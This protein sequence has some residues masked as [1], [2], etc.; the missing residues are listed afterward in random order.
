MT[1]KPKPKPL[2]HKYDTVKERISKNIKRK[3]N[4]SKYN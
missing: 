3:P 2:P 4:G 1:D